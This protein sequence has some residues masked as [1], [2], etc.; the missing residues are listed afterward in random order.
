MKM[1]Q[2]IDFKF[3]KFLFYKI[4]FILKKL[5]KKKIIL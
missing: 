4:Y 1:N 5:I 3:L 2:I